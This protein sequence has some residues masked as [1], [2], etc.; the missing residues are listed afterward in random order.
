MAGKD[1]AKKESRNDRRERLAAERAAQAAKDARQRRLIT[2]GGV[3]VVLAL[4]V[5]IGIAVQSSRNDTTDAALPATVSEPGGPVIRN[6]ETSGVPV[7][8]YWEDFQ[9][10]ACKATED[11]TGS[12]VAGLAAANEVIVRY[13]ML[14]FLD[15]NLRNDSSSRAANAFACSADAGAQGAYHD[16]VYANQPAEEGA[17]YTDEQLLQFGTDAGISGEAFTTFSTCVSDGT[18]DAYVSSV[19]TA[20]AKAGVVTTPTIL[21]NGTALPSEVTSSPQA[22]TAAITAAGPGD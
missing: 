6:P 19:G 2:I 10:P 4:V 7:L 20:G 3:V 5:A 21:L 22:I 14:S 12:T 9:C 16:T 11:A 1:V 8:D 18:Y 13:H 15:G 17:G